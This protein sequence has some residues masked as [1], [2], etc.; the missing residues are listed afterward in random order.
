M[1]FGAFFL[2]TLG[3][4]V[5]KEKQVKR[6]VWGPVSVLWKQSPGPGVQGDTGL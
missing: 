3:Q 6:Q 4:S 1:H 2:G 5:C